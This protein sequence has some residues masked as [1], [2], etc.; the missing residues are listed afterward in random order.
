MRDGVQGDTFKI[1]GNLRGS[2]ETTQW[3][4]PKLY[5]YMRVF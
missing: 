1:K 4:P 3:T 2:M 5:T